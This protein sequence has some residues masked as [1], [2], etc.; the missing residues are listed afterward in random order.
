MEEIAETMKSDA[1][2]ET[3]CKMIS[4]ILTAKPHYFEE[5]QKSDICEK[6]LYSEETDGNHCYECV[7]GESNNF[8][9]E[10]CDDAV[11]RQAVKELFCRICMEQ[12]ICYSSKENCEDL[13]LFDKLPRV[14]PKAKT[15]RWIHKEIT[16]NYRVIGQ[17]SEC[18]ER[19]IIDNFCPNCGADMRRNTNENNN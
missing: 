2:A 18:L 5:P 10:P 1:D 8:R 6:C 12:N 13:K 7:K 3:K 15:G 4:N 19:K 16:D 9:Q 14:Q 11:S 17:C